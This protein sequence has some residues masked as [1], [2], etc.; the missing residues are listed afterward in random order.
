MRGIRAEASNLFR[1]ETSGGDRVR[2]EAKDEGSLLK[3][4]GPAA[5]ATLLA[6]DGTRIPGA[7][8]VAV[9]S[10]PRHL[11]CFLS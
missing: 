8:T 9:P 6:R 5:R 7:G 3:E 2:I 4:S 10:P 1:D 11:L